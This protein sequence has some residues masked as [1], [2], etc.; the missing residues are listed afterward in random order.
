MKGQTSRFYSVEHISDV[1]I[2]DKVKVYDNPFR[3]PNVNVMV[4]DAE[5]NTVT[6]ECPPV[7]MDAAGFPVDA[8][9]LGENYVSAPDTV[10]DRKLKAMNKDAYGV[11]TEQEVKDKRKERVPAFAH[12]D[13]DPMADVTQAQ[14]PAYMRRKGIQHNLDAEERRDE[15]LTHLKAI[16][17]IKAELDVTPDQAQSIKQLLQLEY[18]D[19]ITHEDL[20]TYIQQMRETYVDAKAT[21]F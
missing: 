3:F 16:K 8:P 5:K 2:G 21:S 14:T 17:L 19:G 13:F 9:V 20:T 7:E 18:P 15:K 10:V 11:E 1:A 12:T 6:Y 4:E